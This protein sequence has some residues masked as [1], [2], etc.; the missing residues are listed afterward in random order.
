M[1]KAVGLKSEIGTVAH[2]KRLALKLLFAMSLIVIG[3]SPLIKSPRPW[4][5][6]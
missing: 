5:G 4:A 2:L 3:V 1:L 6:R